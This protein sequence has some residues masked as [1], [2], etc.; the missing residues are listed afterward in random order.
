MDSARQPLARP[1]IVVVLLFAV[2]AG[3]ALGQSTAQLLITIGGLPTGLNNGLVTVTGPGGYRQV[4]SGTASLTSLTPGA[5][6]IAAGTASGPS[7]VYF[8]SVF[9]LVPFKCRPAS[10]PRKRSSTRLSR[11]VGSPLVPSRFRYRSELP[12]LSAQVRFAR[13]Q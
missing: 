8:P 4:L 1:G 2:C 11:V 7:G 3:D 9:P 13:L 6:S 10:P 12:D 5:F